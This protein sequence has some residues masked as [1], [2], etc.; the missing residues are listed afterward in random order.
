MQL[1]GTAL[2]GDKKIRRVGI[3][4]VPLFDAAMSERKA[5]LIRRRY[6]YQFARFESKRPLARGAVAYEESN[7]L[8]ESIG[9]HDHGGPRLVDQRAKQQKC[10]GRANHVLNSLALSR[11]HWIV[12]AT[13]MNHHDT[14]PACA[15]L[16]TPCPRQMPID[17]DQLAEYLRQ[18]AK[19]LAADEQFWL[20]ITGVPGSGKSTL[21]RALL[22][23]LGAA[24]M[25][26]PMDGYHRY[27]RE[28]DQMPDPV[29]AHRR[30]GAPFTFN[31]QRLVREISAARRI[32]VGVFPSFDHVQ[33]DP[34]EE[35]IRLD[36][37]HRIVIVEGIYLLLDDPPWC[38]LREAFDES[39][40]LDVDIEICMDRVRSRFLAMGL[41]RQAAD[42]RVDG[43]DRL[44]AQLAGRA[45]RASAD[46]LLAAR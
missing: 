18:R 42:A 23:R 2:I 13:D 43:N 3:Q 6:R 28:L 34:I 19:N 39:W 35:D 12:D 1:D 10:D 14:M 32:G 40:F 20:G 33:R 45:S 24:A 21:G 9:D 25:V 26:I 15:S 30:R 37:S 8:V 27:R 11:K 29:E 31:A 41:D 44:N 5:T 46:R 38:Q 7:V 17:P 36:R 16:S 22:E 4:Y